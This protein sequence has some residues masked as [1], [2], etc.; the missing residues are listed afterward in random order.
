[1]AAATARAESIQRERA[2]DQ[3]TIR[4]LQSQRTT[5]TRTIE[6]QRRGMAAGRLYALGLFGLLALWLGF[7]APWLVLA[8]VLLAMVATF[9]ATLEWV[10]DTS[11]PWWY[12]LAGGSSWAMRSR[13]VVEM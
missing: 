4:E 2:I 12:L 3:E 13:V 6:Q 9:K 8:V 10:L 5:T 11:R 7:D 1:M